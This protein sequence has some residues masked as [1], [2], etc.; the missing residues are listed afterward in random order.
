ML[1]FNDAFW[2]LGMMFLLVATAFFLT[3]SNHPGSG[4]ASAMH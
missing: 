4:E 1:S 3:R 2:I